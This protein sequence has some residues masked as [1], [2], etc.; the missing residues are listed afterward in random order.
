MTR[1]I[2]WMDDNTGYALQSRILWQIKRDSVH[3]NRE[4]QA[5]DFEPIG[6]SIARRIGARRAARI[7]RA[8]MR[9]SRQHAALT[10]GDE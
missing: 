3:W 2:V 6:D 4:L 1:T 7:V 8:R 9:A 5:I 10:V